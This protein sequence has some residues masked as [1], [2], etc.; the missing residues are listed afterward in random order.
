MEITSQCTIKR[1][2][3]FFKFDKEMRQKI[4]NLKL[5]HILNKQ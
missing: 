1:Y 4:E 2:S 5:L 3:N